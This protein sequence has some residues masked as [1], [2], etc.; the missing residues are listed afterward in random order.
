M[1]D[2]ALAELKERVQSMPQGTLLNLLDASFP[3]IGIE[4]LKVKTRRCRLNS[5]LNTSA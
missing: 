5:G 4:E 3:Y 2:A 1:L